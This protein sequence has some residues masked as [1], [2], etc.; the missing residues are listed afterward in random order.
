MAP[1]SCALC[2]VNRAL[3]LRP[4]DHSKLCKTCFISVFETEIHHTITT[5]ALFQ[6]GEK[7]A[8]G[9]S[10]GKD[11]TVLA[12]VLK[13]L[14]ERYD[15][16]LDLILLSIDEGIKGYRDDSLETVK[17]N[18]EQYGMEL[19]ILGYDELYGWTMDQV[20]EQVGKKGNCTYCGVFRRQAL[21]RGAARL[22]VRHVVTGHNADDV[23]ETVLMN[24]LR[25]DLPRLSRTTSIVTSTPSAS[26][27][28]ASNTNIK[29]SKPLKYAYEKEIVLYAHH[30]N[31]DYFSTECIYSP[32]AFRGS[33]RA[34][35]KN[36][37]RVRPSAILDVVRSGEDM[38]KL[39]PGSDQA[40]GGMCSSSIPAAEEE[41]GGCGS[42]Q[43]RST[44]GDMA[45]VEARLRQNEAAADSNLETEITAKSVSNK[46]HLRR[47]SD[48]VS[49][50]NGNKPKKGF[51][52]KKT[53]KQ[54]MGQCKRCGYLSSQDICK[55]CVL[56]EG[57]NK[58]RP[59]N[60]IEV[61]YE[62]QDVSLNSLRDE[63]EA[64]T[65][66]GK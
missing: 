22:G 39:V 14:N 29:R 42:A 23:A 20:V 60:K 48:A 9:A 17:R 54:V 16:G 27:N 21:D 53:S 18:A 28:P 34:L 15:Y 58:S 43:G 52:P 66:G 37:E 44:G 2:N 64:T 36:L 56:L 13:T 38:A 5:N 62:V 33:A 10:G 12:S 49:L 30:K 47:Q 59:K 57:L 40:C 63:L 26:A 65:V 45:S 8:I 19:T 35:I 61:G 4:K 55:A 46:Q 41:E 11:S 7:V 6:R 3:I 1:A 32:E 31:L 25:G 24:L 51:T 50:A